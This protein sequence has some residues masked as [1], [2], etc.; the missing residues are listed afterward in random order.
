MPRATARKHTILNHRGTARTPG[1]RREDTPMDTDAATAVIDL[2]PSPP[3]STALVPQRQAAGLELWE[4]DTLRAMIKR[5]IELREIMV[6]YMRSQ[7]KPGIHYYTRKDFGEREEDDRGGG[8]PDDKPSLKKE[9][10]LNLCHLLHCKPDPPEVRETFHPDGH[11][12][13]RTLVHIRSLRTGEVVGSGEGL[14]TTRESK[15][16]WRWLWPNQIS[17]LERTGLVTKSVKPRKGPNAGK[18]VTMY[19]VANSSLPDCFN[20]V[21][22]LSYKRGLVAGVLTLPLA[23]ESFTQDVEDGFVDGEDEGGDEG[24]AG[25]PPGSGSSTSVTPESR[26]QRL[27]QEAAQRQAAPAT[28]EPTWSADQVEKMFSSQV[29]EALKKRLGYLAP[30]DL[31]EQH[32]YIR[33]AFGEAAGRFAEAEVLGLSVRKA[34]LLKLLAMP[35]QAPPPTPG[36]TRNVTR[37]PEAEAPLASLQ[38]EGGQD[39][40][41]PAPPS[42]RVGADG[43][44]MPQVVE[45]L[46][47]WA[48][49]RQ[50]AGV[51]EELLRLCPGYPGAPL[52]TEAQW[53]RFVTACQAAMTE[54]DDD[55][56]Y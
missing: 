8:K 41:A 52:V 48:A 38:P 43:Y 18:W 44:V 17:E 36:A 32:S 37:E 35:K 33:Q 7:M 31:S 5:E 47:T 42:L 26:R 12:T 19:R 3:E 2:E 28:G 6:E 27:E 30:G 51:L 34:A 39:T 45:D 29:N 49:A 46:K 50:V 54:L 16:A 4:P 40:G 25:G 24:Q 15:Y 21:L 22:K 20:T 56:P 55:V 10:A 23:S 11:Y 53:L 13:V 9:G 1:P 14:C